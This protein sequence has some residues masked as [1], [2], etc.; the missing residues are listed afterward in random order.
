MTK[1]HR[2]TGHTTA[3]GRLVSGSALALLGLAIVMIELARYWMINHPIH[4]WPVV[5][6]GSIAVFG[7]YL[8]D[9]KATRDGTDLVVDRVASVIAIIRT[10]RRS[11]DRMAITS[12]GHAQPLAVKTLVRPPMVVEDI[13]YPPPDIA[14]M[15]DMHAP[16]DSEG[17]E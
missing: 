11:T 4:P 7:A 13:E 5:I 14:G 3:F 9:P 6:G 12:D 2:P 16:T 10:G 1:Q 15:H 8:L 17:P